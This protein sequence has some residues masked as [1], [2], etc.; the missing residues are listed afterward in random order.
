MVI[1][2]TK[3][4]LDAA[5]G[6]EPIGLKP[7]KSP[8]GGPIITSEHDT[9]YLCSHCEFVLLKSIRKGA[10]RGFLLK[11]PRCNHLSISR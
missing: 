11:C 5:S 1:R 6:K 3:F 2:M 10:M 7:L 9:D 4:K 8:H